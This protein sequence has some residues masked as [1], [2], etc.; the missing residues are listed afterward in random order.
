MAYYLDFVGLNT[1]IYEPVGYDI[2]N[3]VVGVTSERERILTVSGVRTRAVELNTIGF[4]SDGQQGINN[5]KNANFSHNLPTTA[6]FFPALMIKRNGPYG[7]NSFKQIRIS[8]NPLSRKQRKEN[9]FTFVTEP[10]DEVVINNN[11]KISTIRN[12]YGAIQKFT[13]NPVASRYKP[14]IVGGAS[15]IGDGTIERFE[16][17]ASYGNETIFFNNE[18][19]NT[20]N[21][22]RVLRSSQYNTLKDFYLNGGLDADGSPIDSFEFFK[23]R[24][25][26]YPSRVYQY[27]NYTRQ[28]TTFSFP[29]RDDRANRAEDVNDNGFGSSAGMSVYNTLSQSVCENI[30]TEAFSCIAS[31]LSGFEVGVV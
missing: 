27:K 20:Y 17:I 24:E 3:Q 15:I 21:G 10:G 4:G 8:E 31:S 19:I 13:E 18:E 12:K 6:S 28:R 7:Y 5:Y 1:F 30:L 9:V 25:C 22:L 14:F 11:G 16:A 2:E 29:W 26:V 23:Y